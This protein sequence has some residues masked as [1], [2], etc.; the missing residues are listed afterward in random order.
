MGWVVDTFIIHYNSHVVLRWYDND[1]LFREGV[2]IKRTNVEET[3]LDHESALLLKGQDQAY[4]TM[5]MSQDEA[6]S[7][8]LRNSL[9]NLDAMFSVQREHTIFVGSAN[10]ALNFDPEQYFDTVP[11]LVDRSFNRPRKGTLNEMAVHGAMGKG[12]L[13]RAMKGQHKS[14]AGIDMCNVCHALTT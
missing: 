7:R 14:Y 9:Y 10:E 13:K 12:E 3:Q 2:H 8:K 11:E 1:F 4:V 6:K 5:K